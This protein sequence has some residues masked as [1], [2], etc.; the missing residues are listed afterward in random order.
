MAT[1]L[2]TKWATSNKV[3]FFNY[4]CGNKSLLP[5]LSL[6]PILLPTLLPFSFFKSFNFKKF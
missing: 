2:A 5:F 1:I 6:F 4:F 3:H